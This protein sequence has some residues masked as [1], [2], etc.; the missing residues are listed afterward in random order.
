VTWRTWLIFP[1][2]CVLWGMP[3][4]FIKLAL[5]ELSPIAVAWSRLT[6]AALVLVPIALH[7]RVLLPALRHKL[8][9]VAFGI[10]ELVIP[11]SLISF[12]EQWISSSLAGILVAT[13][14]LAIVVIAPF[15]GVKEKLGA[16]RFVGLIV[17]LVGVVA[18]LGVDTGGAPQQW[19]GVLCLFGAVIGYTIGPLIVQRYL[20]GVDQLGALSASLIVA[21]IV[22]LP[23]ALLEVPTALPSSLT[24]TSIGILGIFCTALALLSFFYLINTA[25][26]ARASVVAYICPAVA[27]L[28][29]VLL[30]NEPF[31]F[32]SAAGLALILVGSWMA[33]GGARREPARE[34]AMAQQ[35]VGT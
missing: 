12:G 31:G 29:G 15:F 9:I 22:L 14:P 20:A 11:F 33:T 26:A 25:G 28:L 7:R 16:R 19:L 30:L 5:V 8:A 21:S 32:G 35:E 27:A 18:L 4:F 3:Y 23:W 10:V 2:L 24:L 34:P 13:V 17:G 6:L 1:L